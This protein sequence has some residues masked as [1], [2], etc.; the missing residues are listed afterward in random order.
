[1]KKISIILLTLIFF[2]VIIIWSQNNKTNKDMDPISSKARNKVLERSEQVLI[3]DNNDEQN[4][5]I[6]NDELKVEILNEGQGIAA[7]NG[8]HISV[9]YIGTL[10]DGTKFDSS[11]DRGIPFDFVLGAGQV[12]KGWDLGVLGMK[13]GEKRRLII[14]SD[15]AYGENGIPGAIPPNATL[16]FEVELLGIK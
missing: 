16:I 9:H 12:I 2:A 11:I 4:S 7:Q 10:E 3:L 15:L 6:K 13:I 14:P 8:D 5:E 1:M